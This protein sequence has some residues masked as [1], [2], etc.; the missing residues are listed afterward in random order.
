MK[1]IITLLCLIALSACASKPLEL[2]KSAELDYERGQH[3]VEVE[4]YAKAL[5]FLE[6][7]SAKY[8]YSQYAAGA[9]LLRLK[10]AYNDG[11]FV[12]SEVLSQRFIDAHPDHPDHVYVRYMHAMSLYK[13]SSSAQLDQQFS[14]KA[15]DAFL[16]LN[17][18]YPSNPYSA[19]IQ[20]ELQVLTNRVASYETSVGK[21]YLDKHLYVAAANRFILVKNEYLDANRADEAL[22][23]LV[24]TYRALGQA[25][26]AQETQALLD[27]N[28]A[29][30]PWRNKKS[31]IN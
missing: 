5:I 19:E 24:N 3:L 7:F 25:E 21:F 20:K 17:Q 4:D 26:L 6:K 31:L 14:H 15:R 28:F 8:P 27:K 1:H 11:Q 22:Y 10:A 16:A 2:S 13:Q 18:A 29:A 23:Y 30:S 9:E 12:L